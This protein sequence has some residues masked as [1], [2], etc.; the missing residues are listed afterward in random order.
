MKF[1][2]HLLT[3]HLVQTSLSVFP[4]KLELG[5]ITLTRLDLINCKTFTILHHPYCCY[6]SLYNLFA[7]SSCTSLFILLCTKPTVYCIAHCILLHILLFI[8]PDTSC[9]CLFFYLYLCLSSCV[10]LHILHCPLS[11]PVL[12]Y[13][14]LLIIF[15][16]IEYVTNNK[17]W[18]FLLLNTKEDILKNVG[19]QTAVGSHWLP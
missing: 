15:C 3:L 6:V 14:S 19:I 7:H 8:Y 18:T 2:H 10:V 16:I 11:G 1:F 12:I 4:P 17:P 13:I 9:F 5:L